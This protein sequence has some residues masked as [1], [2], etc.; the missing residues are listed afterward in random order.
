MLKCIR[1]RFFPPG[2]AG[3]DL[4]PERFFRFQ[5]STLS[6][7]GK[8]Q[9]ADCC[10]GD[11]QHHDLP[12]IQSE[13]TAPECKD[14][15]DDETGT[16]CHDFAHGIDPPPEPAEQKQESGSCTDRQNQLESLKRIG[17]LQRQKR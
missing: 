1:F 5:R 6:D 7:P 15:G 17:E 12:R 9:P 2:A 10:Q 16:H 11:G 14:R 13:I 4:L 3:I 8:G